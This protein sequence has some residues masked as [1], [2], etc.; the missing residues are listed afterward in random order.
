MSSDLSVQ[1]Y[2]LL[3]DAAEGA[4]VRQCESSPVLDRLSDWGSP[5]AW[6]REWLFPDFT[7]GGGTYFDRTVS[8]E[9][10]DVIRSPALLVAVQ[11]QRPAQTQQIE[12]IWQRICQQNGIARKSGEEMLTW[13][14]CFFKEKL[15]RLL[16]T[17]DKT[18]GYGDANRDLQLVYLNRH[19]VRAIDLKQLGT[20]PLSGEFSVKGLVERFNNVAFF[21]MAGP[22]GVTD[23]E[24]PAIFRKLKQVRV[25]DLAHCSA[26]A[27]KA[28]AQNFRCLQV[29]KLDQAHCSK[30]ELMQVLRS[31]PQIT[32]LELSQIDGLKDFCGDLPEILSCCPQLKTLKLDD[33]DNLSFYELDKSLRQ[34]PNLEKLVLKRCP[35]LQTWYPSLQ[36]GNSSQFSTHK[37][38]RIL[39]VSECK[40]FNPLPTPAY[41]VINQ[42]P[43]LEQ[44]RFS[45]DAQLGEL[46]DLQLIRQQSSQWNN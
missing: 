21:T 31:N 3:N 4:F 20:D 1:S 7:Q 35:S 44:F 25:L 42:F 46:Q 26:T 10:M 14:D 13:E 43:S 36:M 19:R 28:M 2:K 8:A 5:K 32:H 41:P 29:L 24:W 9:C 45:Y 27:M 33:L 23:D 30:Q 6:F 34:C 12:A 22:H 16:V 38:L 11:N 18:L 17:P 39:E 15:N 37:N 40:N